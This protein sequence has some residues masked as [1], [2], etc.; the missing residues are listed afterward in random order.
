MEEKTH[1]EIQD[2]GVIVGIDGSNQCMAAL[3]WAAD[4]ASRRGT[5]LTLVT[6]YTVPV[7]AASSM[8][9]GYIAMDDGAIRAGAEAV[10]KDA[11]EALSG[12]SGPIQTVV[13]VGD[14]AGVLVDLSKRAEVLAVGSRGRGGFI[15]RLLGS[16]SSALPA[17]AK[18]ATVVVPIEYA[19]HITER[20]TA[21]GKEVGPV[22]V[23]VDGS[24]QGRL[25]SLRAAEAAQQRGT[26]LVVVSA[27]PPL[28]G[29]V[30]WLPTMV[31][32]REITKDI[33]EKLDAG[34]AWLR[35][36]YPDLDIST[37]L[38]DGAPVDVLIEE[39]KNAQLTVVGTRGRGGFTGMLLGSTSQGVLTY[40]QGPV[41]VVPDGEDPRLE[42]RKDFGPVLD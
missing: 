39:T 8:D 1:T 26:N 4:E 41:M 14:A 40:A 2:P 37:K 15:G 36:Y 34:A 18:C 23:G 25:A 32:E 3:G 31:D 27:L 22:V 24:D 19:K 9:A 42:T 6:A 35:S 30:A 11:M 7:F 20:T 29:A 16:V 12:Y 17:H 10:L 13:E 38:V 28:G 21:E 33:Q 5:M